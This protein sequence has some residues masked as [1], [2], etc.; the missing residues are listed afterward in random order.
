[1]RR[2]R[3]SDILMAMLT[4][5]G[6]RKP[7]ADVQCGSLMHIQA[8]MGHLSLDTIERMV[9]TPEY[10]IKIADHTRT[11]CSSILLEEG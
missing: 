6:S 4:T 5:A 9:H 3:S 1:M 7:A 2:K 8:R 11:A 10:G